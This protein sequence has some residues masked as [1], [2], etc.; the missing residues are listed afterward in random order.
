M[1]CTI[2]TV[3]PCTLHLTNRMLR[4]SNHEVAT[5]HTSQESRH[6]TILASSVSVVQGN[7]ILCLN[8]SRRCEVRMHLTKV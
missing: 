3:T 8:G 6:D 4:G 2:V 5:G 1:Q 7:L